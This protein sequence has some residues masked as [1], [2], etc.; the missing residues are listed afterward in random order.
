[1]L[2]SAKTEEAL[3]K[4]N[5]IITSNHFDGAYRTFNPSSIG[6]N[7]LIA[8][9]FFNVQGATGVMAGFTNKLF[10]NNIGNEHIE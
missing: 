9:N 8:N 10:V 2:K 7:V 5:Y 1:M 6:S 3:S 4:R